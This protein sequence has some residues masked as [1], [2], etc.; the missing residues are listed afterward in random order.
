MGS[1]YLLLGEYKTYLME[2]D[3]QFAIRRVHHR[4]FDVRLFCLIVMYVIVMWCMRLIH[5]FVCCIRIIFV[6]L[7]QKFHNKLIC[8][9]V[10]LNCKYL[11]IFDEY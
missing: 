10:I 11:N 5:D 1:F 9:H 3:S 4:V 8:Y 6:D 2:Y 7:I